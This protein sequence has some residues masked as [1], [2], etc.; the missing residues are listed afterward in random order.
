MKAL[1]PNIYTAPELGKYL[2][3]AGKWKKEFTQGCSFRAF[4][5]R[6]C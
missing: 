1:A 3:Q 2:A 6:P 5:L 4:M